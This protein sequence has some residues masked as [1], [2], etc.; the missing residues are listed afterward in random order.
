MIRICRQTE[1]PQSSLS[2]LGFDKRTQ[3]RHLLASDASQQG[4][5]DR[6]LG[7]VSSVTVLTSPGGY[8]AR[9][10]RFCPLLRTI[11]ISTSIPGIGI[12]R[13]PAFQ[14]L[15]VPHHLFLTRVPATAA[16]C[17]LPPLLSMLRTLVAPS[18]ISERSPWL[19]RGAI[20]LDDASFITRTAVNGGATVVPTAWLR[21][22]PRHRF[23][24][25]FHLT[26]HVGSHVFGGCCHL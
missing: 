22:A 10:A 12:T 6:R 7:P 4:T 21:S 23:S 3:E 2:P 20:T 16:R 9:P 13:V 18:L 19:V 24:P 17:W 5:V 1:A 26:R 11:G 25:Y 15:S 8:A 14:W